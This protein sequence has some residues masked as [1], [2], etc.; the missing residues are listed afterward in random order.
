MSLRP[1]NIFMGCAVVGLFAL[2]GYIGWRVAEPPAHETAD[3]DEQRQVQVVF[4]SHVRGG[5]PVR[6]APDE[7]VQLVTPGIEHRNTY[8]FEN[9]S[10]KPVFFTP[11]HS[12]SPPDAARHY[13]MSVCFCFY[14]QTMPARSRATF[15]VAY[16]LNPALNHRTNPVHINYNLVGIDPEQFRRSPPNGDDGHGLDSEIQVISMHIEPLSS[17]VEGYHDDIA[18][19]EL[20]FETKGVH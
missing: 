5:L 20:H 14:D 16:T 3:I 1:L 4:Q 13:S 2:A 17:P 8:T 10:D 19:A 9:L 15:T 11:M 7:R 12:V 18:W 6:F